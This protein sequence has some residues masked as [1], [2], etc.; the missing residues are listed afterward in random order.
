[1]LAAVTAQL[2]AVLARER[3]VGVPAA[4]RMQT[5]AVVGRVDSS[6]LDEQT[7]TLDAVRAVAAAVASPG[8]VQVLVSG[9]VGDQ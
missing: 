3:T 2:V 7:A 1:V 5:A 6:M 9:D 8:T 4:Q